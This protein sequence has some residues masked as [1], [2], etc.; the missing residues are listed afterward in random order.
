MPAHFPRPTTLSLSAGRE[1]REPPSW[2]VRGRGAAGRV[3]SGDDHTGTRPGCRAPPR[4]RGGG[5][6]PSGQAPARR[7]RRRS[8]H[9]AWARRQGGQAGRGTGQRDRAA[10]SGDGGAYTAGAPS[11][12]QEK[13]VRH[14][15]RVKNKTHRGTNTTHNNGSN[16]TDRKKNGGSIWAALVACLSIED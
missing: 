4:A 9:S 1:S 13:R 8:G 3:Q 16:R 7:G 10:R 6:G 11:P 12:G 14:S 5:R 2:R 15:C